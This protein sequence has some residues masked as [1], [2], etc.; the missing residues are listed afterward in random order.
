MSQDYDDVEKM[1]L[2]M[3]IEQEGELVSHQQEK[4]WKNDSWMRIIKAGYSGPLAES[5]ANRFEEKDYDYTTPEGV[6]ISNVFF[7]LPGQTWS[8]LDRPSDKGSKDLP[9]SKINQVERWRPKLTGVMKTQAQVLE[10]GIKTCYPLVELVGNCAYG[11]T[12]ER[13]CYCCL[14]N[15]WQ[16]GPIHLE[17]WHE[18][19]IVIVEGVEYRVKRFPTGDR[20]YQGALWEMYYQEGWH[21][22]RPREI[23]KLV[24]SDDKILSQVT[25]PMLNPKTNFSALSQQIMAKV[26]VEGAQGPVLV[27]QRGIWDMVGGKQ[28]LAD[29]SPMDVAR[30]EYEEELKVTPPELVFIGKVNLERFQLYLYYA[31]DSRIQG[32]ADPSLLQDLQRKAWDE[33]FKRAEGK[34][35]APTILSQGF[36]ARDSFPFPVLRSYSDGTRFYSYNVSLLGIVSVES[37][38]EQVGLAKA[39]KDMYSTVVGNAFF[40]HRIQDLRH[41]YMLMEFSRSWKMK[42]EVEGSI[43]RAWTPAQKLRVYRSE[44]LSIPKDRWVPIAKDFEDYDSCNLF[45]LAFEYVTEGNVLEEDAVR[46]WL[47]TKDTS[48]NASDILS[49]SGELTMFK[50]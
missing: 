14:Y 50:H 21:P 20:I 22:I 11:I 41:N 16:K 44:R 37:F 4:A 38:I 29:Q 47:V 24:Q 49:M 28:T 7:P 15:K 36:R 30:R 35:F 27:Q 8:I 26:Y 39:L 32:G 40:E 33:F 42:F 2:Q 48:W 5:I 43:F 9:L 31:S 13:H 46:R 34:L 19:V 45:D 25:L 23:G 17:P 18:G 6:V 3:I 12:E 1:M 10:K